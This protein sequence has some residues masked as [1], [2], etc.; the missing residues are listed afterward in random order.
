MS[1]KNYTDLKY[2]LVKF[3]YGNYNANGVKTHSCS[4]EKMISVLLEKQHMIIDNHKWPKQIN[5]DNCGGIINIC[6]DSLFNKKYLPVIDID[7]T[8]ILPSLKFIF[9]TYGLYSVVF[10]SSPGKHWVFVKKFMS[11]KNAINIMK[12]VPGN[13]ENFVQCCEDSKSIVIRAFPKIIASQPYRPRK[14]DLLEYKNYEKDW[15]SNSFILKYRKEE[16]F[17]LDIEMYFLSTH[18]DK[19]FNKL[20]YFMEIKIMNAINSVPSYPD[21]PHIPL[22]NNNIVNSFADIQHINL[23]GYGSST[24]SEESEAPIENIDDNVDD[25]SSNDEKIKMI[26][27]KGLS[28]P[29]CIDTDNKDVNEEIIQENI[30]NPIQFVELKD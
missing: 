3:Y 27:M 24:S 15:T 18:F 11:F 9:E 28:I 14:A 7:S 6:N 20:K 12:S 2:G 4:L 25:N 23:G 16:E 17:L 5:S 30:T 19:L 22:G 1:Y 29:Q 10:E 8:N 13:D 26:M 21:I